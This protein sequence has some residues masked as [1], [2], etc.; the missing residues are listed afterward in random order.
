MFMHSAAGCWLWSWLD[1][2]GAVLFESDG[3][4]HG[5]EEMSESHAEGQGL[6]GGAASPQAPAVS[7]TRP[8]M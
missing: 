7:G 1:C 2:C 3:E 6:C 4:P 5:G 8:M